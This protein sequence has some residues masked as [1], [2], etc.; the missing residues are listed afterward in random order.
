MAHALA[1]ADIPT[2]VKTQLKYIILISRSK[3]PASPKSEEIAT[4]RSNGFEKLSPRL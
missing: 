4:V 2:T 3:E 1:R